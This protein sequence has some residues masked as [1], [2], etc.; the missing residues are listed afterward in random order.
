MN[1]ALVGSL[2]LVLVILEIHAI[3]CRVGIY[4]LRHMP[5]EDVQSLGICQEAALS[6]IAHRK[7]RRFTGDDWDGI[8][9][10]PV[11]RVLEGTVPV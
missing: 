9:N 3:S 10:L 2:N 1:T 5:K 7:S 8:S 6:D 11:A 4:M